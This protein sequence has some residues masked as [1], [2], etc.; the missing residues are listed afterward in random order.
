MKVSPTLSQAD[1]LKSP[2]PVS[3]LRVW[4]IVLSR[5][6]SQRLTGKALR[7]LGGKPLAGWY[8]QALADAPG[9][10]RKYL[11]TD[12]PAL[13]QYVN[14]TFTGS[15]AESPFP[16]PAALSQASTSSFETLRWFLR[17]FPP[18]T[19]PDAIC[20]GQLTT[21]F[22]HPEDVTGALSL[23]AQHYAQ[24]PST[25]IISVTRPLK[26]TG[27]LQGVN[28]ASG[29]LERLSTPSE[30]VAP[31]VYP[32]GALYLLPTQALLES[33][34]PFDWETLAA[35]YP[36]EMPWVRSVDVDTL[37]DL[38]LAQCLMHHGYVPSLTGNETHPVVTTTSYETMPPLSV[39]PLLEDPLTAMAGA[40]EPPV[41]PPAKLHSTVQLPPPFQRKDVS[42][43]DDISPA[44]PE[45]IT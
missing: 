6:G 35:V 13:N 29:K 36:Y 5:K 33:E 11:V 38:E 27:W 26:P 4:S 23:F 16:R 30:V 2:S 14:N 17:Q 43:H 41:P 28:A 7:P 1:R 31:C 19:L 34:G 20:L 18:H 45:R 21:P 44:K 8:L 25:G 37:E 24:T 32:N 10:E 42:R 9:L 22:L 3:H 40:S 15:I 39:S 12:D